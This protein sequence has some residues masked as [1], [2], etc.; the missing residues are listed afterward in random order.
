ML[1]IFDMDGTLIDS[2]VVLTNAI[3]YVRGKLGL[4]PLDSKT[5]LEQINNPSCN[6]AQFFYGIDKIEP[7]HEKWFQEYYSAMH[8]R[9]IVLFDGIEQMLKELK[10]LKIKLA[11][12]TNAYRNSALEALKY[13]KIDRYFDDIICW[14]DVK[15]G[16]PSPEMLIKLMQRNCETPNTTVF[17]G[18][19]DR[20]ELAAKAARV[21]FI[22][23]AFSTGN[24]K[25]LNSPMQLAKE[26]E[27]F[28]LYNYAKA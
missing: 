25:L 28:F 2:S 16:K 21:K 15:E 17:V 27:E 13:L 23:V 12:A 4:K 24:S 18:D 1:A 11:I 19:S 3:N 22:R 7:I 5:V 14:D 8:D 6:L 20:D 10:S 9:E 26:I